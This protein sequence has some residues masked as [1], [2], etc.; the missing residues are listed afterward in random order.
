ML[1][2]FVSFERLEDFIQHVLDYEE[3]EAKNDAQFQASN[4]KGESN[5]YKWSTPLKKTLTNNEILSQSIFFL[6]A[7]YDTTSTV[8]CFVVYQL[9]LNP[10][11]QQRL[12]EEVDKALEKSVPI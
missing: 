4:V 2:N 5:D 7:G 12:C 1:Y 3:T 8:I 6:A 10:R 11:Y 9:D